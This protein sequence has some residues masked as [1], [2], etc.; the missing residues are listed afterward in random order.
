MQK[1]AMLA[2]GE[3]RGWPGWWVIEVLIEDESA[4]GTW[5][6]VRPPDGA[7]RAVMAVDYFLGIEIGDQILDRKLATQCED[8][9]SQLRQKVEEVAA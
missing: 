4:L 2:G 1:P 7:Y 9:Y 3:L 5:M 6:V 8:F